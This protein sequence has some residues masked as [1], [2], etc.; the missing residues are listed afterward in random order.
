MPIYTF[1]CKCGNEIDVLTDSCDMDLRMCSKCGCGMKRL[2]G[3]TG[4]PQFKGSG[5][6]E[7]DYKKKAKPG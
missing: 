7:T 3:K 5:F 1:R 2:V 6:Y 4:K